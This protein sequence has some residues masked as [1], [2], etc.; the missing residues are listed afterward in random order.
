MSMVSSAT[1]AQD[2]FTAGGAMVAAGEGVGR[3]TLAGGGVALGALGL[4]DGIAGARSDVAGSPN[5]SVG[6]GR[7]A[8]DGRGNLGDCR[9]GS[10]A[11]G[12]ACAGASIQGGRA[13]SADAVPVTGAAQGSAGGG[14][15]GGWAGPRGAPP[16]GMVPSPMV[17]QLFGAG[18]AWV[19]TAGAAPV[20]A[21]AAFGA[22]ARGSAGFDA[23]ARVVG[24]GSA[25]G[26][27][28]SRTGA[29]RTELVDAHAAGRA[30][31]GSGT[32]VDVPGRVAPVA[33]AFGFEATV[34][35][36]GEGGRGI[37]VEVVPGTSG[38]LVVAAAAGL[39]P[40]GLA[41]VSGAGDEV[42]VDPAAGISTRISLPQLQ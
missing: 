22:A 15:F 23:P 38:T 6:G 24:G 21:A 11:T 20:R 35:A 4:I 25:T 40:G 30:G 28:V 39:A 18:V 36:E 7:L 41:G 32:A 1:L 3:S 12:G 37:E 14:P 31:G 17:A 16:F 9:A 2:A 33:G 19:G 27:A 26:L 34:G 10:G 8:S 13:A 29:G 5:R 42:V